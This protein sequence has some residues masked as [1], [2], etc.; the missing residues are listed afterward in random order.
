LKHGKAV[1]PNVRG[2]KAIVF[3]GLKV[4]PSKPTDSQLEKINR[5]T[6][7]PFTVDE[8]YVGQLRLANNCVDRDTERFSEEVLQRFAATAIRRTMLF[9]HNR[10][11]QVSAIGKFFDVEV[12]KM[13][14]QQALQETG[15]DLQLP[16]GITDVWFLSPWFYIPVKG[17][18][19]ETI[20]KIDA[21]IY[22][23]ASIGFRAESLVPVMDKEGDIQFWEYRG[24]GRRTEMTEGS[25]VYLGAQYGMA[26]KSYGEDDDGKG[27][28]SFSA[29]T[30]APENRTWDA[31]AAKKRIAKWASSD[32]SGDKDKIDWAKYRKAF[33]WYDAENPENF[34]SYKL[35][36]HD[37]ID[38][39]LSVV[40][41]GVAGCMAACR[42]SRGGVDIPQ[43]DMPAVISHL[44]KHYK[45]FDKEP[46][47]AFDIDNY[48]EGGIA[49]KGLLRI[50]GKLFPGV[51]F[52][53]EGI[54]DEIKDAVE[55]MKQKAKEALDEVKESLKV[56]TQELVASE[57]KVKELTPLAADGKAFRD[58]LISQYVASKAKLSEVSEKEEEQKELRTIA[59]GY[60]I[61]FLRAEVKHLEARVAEKFPDKSQLGGGKAGENA[62]TDKGAP[63]GE[64]KNPLIPDEE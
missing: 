50:L 34:G 23:F 28:V 6:R 19:E 55:A 63:S 7:R 4:T 56:K 45:Q 36:H 16:D 60:P 20:V 39:E 24:N 42:G 29:T 27:A 26:V 21:G 1:I 25:L 22:D 54:A 57:A 10:Q 46:P 64:E 5:F 49:M 32:G 31:A 17:V 59:A 43:A 38:G 11:A 35:P 18:S 52:T 48:N 14:L 8:I 13:P 37:V 62:R 15:E 41:N 44:T 61:E 12:E 53:E 3:N 51:M 9:D 47:K 2:T 30:T 58:D 40:W 33:A